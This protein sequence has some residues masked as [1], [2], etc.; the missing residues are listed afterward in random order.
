MRRLQKLLGFGLLASELSHVFCC[1]LPSLFSLATFLV[2]V[3]FLS[4]MP[5]FFSDAHDALH[6]WE[7]PMIIGS[8]VMVLLGWGIH[9]YSVVF[10]CHTTGCQHGSCQP[11]KRKTS[12]ILVVA[13]ALFVVNVCVY[14]AVHYGGDGLLDV[15]A[16]ADSKHADHVH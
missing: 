1:I 9:F 7:V 4:A 13:S 12:R 3:G 11:A 2:A 15:Y 6:D 5:V 8:A 14:M 16:V 10:D